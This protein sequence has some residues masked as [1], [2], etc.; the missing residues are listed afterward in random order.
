M[1]TVALDN[2]LGLIVLPLPPP[3]PHPPQLW[4]MTTHGA[5]VRVQ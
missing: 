3:A 4:E 2:P 5:I 1:D